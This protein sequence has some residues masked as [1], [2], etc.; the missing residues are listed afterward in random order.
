MSAIANAP[1]GAHAPVPQ[2]SRSIATRQ[3]LLQ[4]TV[5][6]LVELGHAHTTT[7]EICRRAG[8]SQGAL[9]RHFPSKALLLAATSAYLLSGFIEDYRTSYEAIAP[10]ADPVKSAVD[11]LL[12]ESRRLGLPALF[13]LI[14]AARTDK[15][16]R[17][18]L[19]PVMAEHREN[20]HGVARAMF[21]NAARRG[22]EFDAAVDGVLSAIQGAAMSRMLAPDPE[23]EQRHIAFITRIAASELAAEHD[24]PTS[25]VSGNH[26][27]E[28][29]K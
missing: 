20:I 10:D 29:G 21:P 28:P 25:V 14:T 22:A 1:A 6:S 8:V 23:A 15:D 24:T 2:Q 16:L 3:R 9:F 13:E 12:D 19:A 26:A 7:P 5:D 18:A 4:A 27:T 11:L 17:A